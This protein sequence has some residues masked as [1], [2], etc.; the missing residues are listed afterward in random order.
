M[1]QASG[2]RAYSA[3]SAAAVDPP[4][5]N[6][7]MKQ[8]QAGWT[9]AEL[10]EIE[11]HRLAK[12]F[13]WMDRSSVPSGRKLVKMT[14]AYKVK[15]SGKL[16][17]RLCVQGCSQIPG[18]DYDQTH[19]STMRSGSLR[20]LSS[21]A[22]KHGL[23]MRR[24]DFVAAFLQGELLD[25][26]VVY[27]SAPP[28]YPR[29]GSDGQPQ[30]V[31][32][33]KPIY[34]MAQAGRRWQR[35]LYPWMR[36]QLGP[37][38]QLFSDSNVFSCVRTNIVN[39]TPRVERLIVGCYVDDLYILAS[40][41]DADSLYAQ[42][43]TSLQKRWD[44]EDEGVVSD[45][46]GIEI[47]ST[48]ST[49]ELK[50]EAYINKLVAI[51]FPDGVPSTLQST[52]TP[53]DADLA[54]HVA[55][56]LSCD[57]PRSAEDIRRFQSIVG[58]LLYASTN[59]RPD[60]AYAVGMLCR[61]MGKPT[62][63]LQDAALRVL[64]YLHR[65][66]HLGLRYE[67]D[68]TSA[69]GMTD[70]DWAVKHSTT[71]WVFMYNQA[72][73]SWSS[74]KQTSVALSSCEAEI[75]AAS[76][77]AKEG[78]HLQRFLAELGENASHPLSLSTDNTGARDLAYNPEHHQRVKH[79]ERR[80]FF[81]R[82]CVENMQLTVPY[83]NTADNIADFFTKS[84]SSKQFFKLRDQIMN[85]PPEHQHQSSLRALRAVRA[86]R[87][88]CGSTDGG[89]LNDELGSLTAE[90][91]SALPAATSDTPTAPVAAPD[92]HIV[93]IVPVAGPGRAMIDTPRAHVTGMS[94]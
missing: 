83:V 78:I 76:E 20:L 34:G 87:S 81:I 30:V 50:Q 33:Q 48:G 71:G 66:R 65:T 59:T 61:C 67:A 49:V 88:P 45:L 23:S 73:I 56:A 74:K 37:K 21:L 41:Q 40:H 51:W 27:C 80:H 31:R 75:M 1:G 43:T 25:N 86:D 57:A 82:E 2:P 18:V 60:I 35:T 53:A 85:V 39:G 79:I 6:A 84:L 7:A 22:A 70:S 14:W 90:V 94:T 92:T 10:D 64:G 93:P 3:T 36:E 28:G 72:A 4:H 9:A 47:S 19:C 11:N 17:A 46:L 12:S 68:S 24:W 54:Q 29:V 32:I 38:S 5:R 16:K 44:V 52:K 42:F 15:R 89:V 58:A 8:N 77:A 69:Y 63:A 13:A 55:D 26:E 91:I 62:P